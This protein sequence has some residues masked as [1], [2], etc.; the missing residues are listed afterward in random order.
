[1]SVSLLK[2]RSLKLIIIGIIIVIALYSNKSINL[3]GLHILYTMDSRENI[4][5]I[6]VD[7]S[8][9]VATRNDN[10]S[11]NPILRLKLFLNQFIM[12]EWKKKHNISVEVNVI[13]WNYIE[14]SPHVNE[15]KEI[16][17]L[18]DYNRMHKNAVIKFYKIPSQYNDTQNCLQK[19]K[20]QCVFP[21]YFAK[22]VGIRRSKGKW[23]LITNMDDVFSIQLMNLLGT[24]I[25]NNS[26]DINGIY[27]AGW[28]ERN[29]TEII[30]NHTDLSL[31]KTMYDTNTTP[32]PLKECIQ[33]LKVDGGGIMGWAGDFALLRREHIFN[34]Y[35]G[36]YLEMCSS[37]NLDTEFIA[38]QLYINNLNSYRISHKCSY[39][40]IKHERNQKKRKK[41]PCFKSYSNRLW[42]YII[43]NQTL[44][45]NT[46]NIGSIKSIIN[47]ND[48]YTFSN[49]T[50]GIKNISFKPH[51][52]Y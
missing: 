31:I 26:L 37:S 38:R 44:R 47:W 52:Y 8:I 20:L 51:V 25:S 39:V 21:Q 34:N 13:E 28:D 41:N 22:N 15:Y 18:L 17:D 30:L 42:R 9:I 2:Q 4:N 40:H 11:S 5:D 48:I 43:R 16:K 35:V 23:V 12:Y 19:H 3:N 50:W 46:E 7:L 10:H 29:Y 6:N 14:N 32:F 36:G 1:M 24:H 33:Q 27:Q 45:N 49:N